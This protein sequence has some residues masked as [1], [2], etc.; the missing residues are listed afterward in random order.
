MLFRSAWVFRLVRGK[1][2][3]TVDMVYPINDCLILLG[4]LEWVDSSK[5]DKLFQDSS[6]QVSKWYNRV[7]R[8]KDGTITSVGFE[9][10]YVTKDESKCLHSLRHNYG[11][12]VYAVTTDIKATADAMGHAPVAGA[13][14]NRYI[15][16]LK[17]Q[18]R[19]ELASKLKF[20]IDLDA[21]EKRV[22]EL[23]GIKPS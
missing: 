7:D 19:L 13:I 21:L 9:Y 17:M 8:D 1:S 18:T 5:R 11:G 14:T 10:D 16:A 23:F 4:F 3:N 22:E 12:E 2:R 15:G 20:N 6:V